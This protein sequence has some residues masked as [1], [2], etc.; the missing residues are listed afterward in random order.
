MNGM[1]AFIVNSVKITPTSIHPF[2]KYVILHLFLPQ[3]QYTELHIVYRGR[4]GDRGGG[5]KVMLSFAAVYKYSM[6]NYA[7]ILRF[8]TYSGGIFQFG[9]Q[10]AYFPTQENYCSY[11]SM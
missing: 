1:L 4:G 7:Q 6:S 11:I 3:Y 10:P 8:N 9:N 5:F 2:A